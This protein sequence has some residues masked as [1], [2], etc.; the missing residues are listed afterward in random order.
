MLRPP[1]QLEIINKNNESKNVLLKG[2]L[3]AFLIDN[4]QVLL[5]AGRVLLLAVTVCAAA[6]CRRRSGVACP[7]GLT[8]GT[9]SPGRT[10][11]N[12]T[13]DQFIHI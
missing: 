2:F 12:T 7:T 4:L 1:V 10:E 11:E 6:C 8:S 5:T 9:I 3:G 13:A